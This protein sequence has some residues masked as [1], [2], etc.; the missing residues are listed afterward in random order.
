M[1]YDLFNECLTAVRETGTGKGFDNDPLSIRE[2][3]AEFVTVYEILHSEAHTVQQRVAFTINE[4]L[5]SFV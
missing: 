2:N 1:R 4:E 5:C 3:N